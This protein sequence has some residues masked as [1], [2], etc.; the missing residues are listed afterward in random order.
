MSNTLDLGDNLDLEAPKQGNPIG[1]VK[2]DGES[3]NPIRGA[4]RVRIV[5][6]DNDTI[7]PT[8]Q[9]IGVNGKGYILRPNEEADV[10]IEILSVL[11]D[12]VEDA[13]VFGG[14]SR[15]LGWRKKKRFPYRIV[16]P[17]E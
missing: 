3:R 8:G 9:F 10:P 17:I 1:E 15:V 6:E 2:V 16:R 14:D 11:D 4:K 5:L 7:P 12:A 13:P